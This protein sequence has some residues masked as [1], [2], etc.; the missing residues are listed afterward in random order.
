M[1]LGDRVEVKHTKHDFA[2]EQKNI[3]RLLGC[4]GQEALLESQL[5]RLVGVGVWWCGSCRVERSASAE[6]KSLEFPGRTTRL[7][8]NSLVKVFRKYSGS[9]VGREDYWV[10][11]C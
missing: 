7:S 2:I 9:V 5:R 6:A 10:G 11:E 1:G 8:P 3:A 4:L